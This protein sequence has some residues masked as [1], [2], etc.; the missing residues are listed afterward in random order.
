[1]EAENYTAKD[2]GKGDFSGMKWAIYSDADA[3]GG[4]YT[5][6]PDNGNAN[7]GDS[8][9]APR[10]DFTVNFAKTGEHF[11]WVRALTPGGTNDSCTPVYDGDVVTQWHMGQSDDW[12]WKKCDTTFAASTGTRTFSIRMREDGTEI[13]KIVLTTDPDYDPSTV[14]GGLGPQET[15]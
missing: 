2:S 10:L 15:R 5:M 1:M 14:N 11:I 8:S 13:D 3:T 9:D 12:T 7:A 6:V 4:S